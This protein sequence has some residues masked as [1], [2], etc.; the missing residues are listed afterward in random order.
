MRSLS[1]FYVSGNYLD[2]PNIE[3]ILSRMPNL[4]KVGLD[5]T[6][7]PSVPTG[8]FYN[9]PRL[10][11]VN[12][13]GNY[14]VNFDESIVYSLKNLAVLDLSHNYLMGMDA[15]LKDA[16]LSYKSDQLKMVYL[17]VIRISRR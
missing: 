17:Q 5:Q 11:E 15:G 14:L 12:V 3:L 1:E 6:G 16:L 13:S 10:R 9:N 2:I 8:M 4:E 7:L